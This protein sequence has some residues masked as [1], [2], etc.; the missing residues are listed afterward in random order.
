MAFNR[1]ISP[2]A[3]LI[4][5]EPT[6]EAT[7]EEQI[8]SLDGAPQNDLLAFALN[9]TDDRMRGAAVSRLT[10]FDLLLTL[11]AEAA[12]VSHL[13]QSRL[14][15]LVD[16]GSVDF[17]EL[18]DT[19][20]G[21]D[22]LLT[23]AALCSDPK[24]LSALIA[25]MSDP[26]Q[27][28][29]L[30]VSG[31]TSR[32]RQVAAER[33][34]DPEQL[35]QL[36]AQIRGRDNGAYKVL[37][38]NQ[39]AIQATELHAQQHASALQLACDALER[40]AGRVYDAAYEATFRFVRDQWLSLDSSAAPQSQQ[41]AQH[42]IRRCE[43][44][45][46]E[47]QRR[48]TESAAATAAAALEAAARQAALAAETALAETE[49]QRQLQVA[50]VAADEAARE[51]AAAEQAHAEQLAARLAV[52]IAGQRQIAGLLAKANSALDAGDTG[53][54]AGVQRAIAEKLADMPALPAHLARQVQQLDVKLDELKAW[55]DYAAAPKRAE[56]IQGMEG[57]VG[58][59]DEPKVVAERIKQLQAEWKT[60]SKGLVSDSGADWQRFQAAAEAAYQPCREYFAT[61]AKQRQERLERRN[62]VLR[63]LSVFEAAQAGEQPDFGAIAIVLR[64]ARLEWRRHSAVDRAAG[65]RG[66][67]Q[68]DAAMTRLADRLNA[69]H[70]ANIAAK[71]S[72]IER[73]Q[74]LLEKSD[75]REATDAAKSLQQEWKNI[76]AAPR[77]HE[78]RL[79]E[80]FRKQC[81][82]VFQK[83]QHAHTQY[84]AGLEANRM[85][86]VA[87]CGEVEQA[88]QSHFG[89]LPDAAAQI[90]QWHAAFDSIGELPR[91]QQRFLMERFERALQAIQ[92]TMEQGRVRAREQS[93]IQLL[94]AARHINDFGWATA[95]GFDASERETAKSAGEDYIAAVAQWP[96]GGAQALKDAWQKAASATDSATAANEKALRML[97]VRSEIVAERS[98]PTEDSGLRRE[99]QVARLMQRMGHGADADAGNLDALLLEWVRTGPVHPAHFE[100]LLRRFLLCRSTSIVV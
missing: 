18:K 99:Y 32:I 4:G 26:Q 53:R 94:E 19:G 72:L 95:Q 35:R 73:A 34:H 7:L 17:A 64:E 66:Q 71:Q 21:V 2:L 85:R 67:K 70:S 57:L 33:V 29:A 90:S 76:G 25:A 83:R 37:R 91:G 9:A 16:G 13:A 56:L 52:E 5:T 8:A 14:A 100:A 63:R 58:S 45:I 47:H 80:E 75:G 28:A 60:V 54:A 55:K 10:D 79:W 1:L 78:Q 6:P 48:A 49:H 50:A 12:E 24:H 82:A 68:F 84:T 81:D 69:W 87:L 42:A 46:A 88:A 38:R 11:A 41:R 65:A 98:T 77:D 62:E 27:I 39:D 96:K 36:I 44:V 30:V 59:T 23:I 40:H 97:C 61:Q 22:A 89:P 92:R 93:C 43:E 51:R 86:A 31:A 15:Y 20:A 3:R 74:A